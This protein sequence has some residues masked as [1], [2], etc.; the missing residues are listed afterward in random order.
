MP[1]PSVLVLYNEPLLPKDHPDA[2]SEHT[3]VEIAEGME[4][5]LRADGLRT[6]LMG[7]G[8]DP[9]KLWA[10]LKSRKCDVVLNLF[11]GN[12]DDTETESYIAGLLQWSG[13]PFTGSPSQA[14]SL[15]RAKHT[16]KTL[17]RGAGLPTAD[18][19][20]VESLPVPEC[21]LDWPVIVKAAKQDASVGLDQDSVCTDSFQLEQ[22]V[23]YILET[24]G[25]PVLVEEYVDGR[26]FNVALI[27]VPELQYLPPAE[28]VFE[29][30]AGTWP[31][32][33]YDGKW[34]PTSDA[35]QGTPP[36]YPADIPRRWAKKLGDIAMKAYRLMGC[37]D[38]ARVDFRVTADGKP[39]ILEV[40]PNPEISDEAGFASCL[41]SANMSYQSFVCRLVRHALE[42][43]P[44]VLPSLGLPPDKGR[45]RLQPATDPAS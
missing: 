14:M 13:V 34:K 30:K 23:A 38:Y 31:I 21:T 4:Q 26:E 9:S 42:R 33:T 37:Q 17:L 35:Y 20:V 7:V 8:R 16:A 39:F 2:E 28:I 6:Q 45:S 12:L 43:G 24:Y 10:A 5:I 44:R 22:R 29:E 27:E 25:A 15:A 18:F 40:N 32:L 1:A 41:I 3:V 11:E 19:M 36:K